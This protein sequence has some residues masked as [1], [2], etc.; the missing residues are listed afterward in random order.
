VDHALALRQAKSRFT[1]LRQDRKAREAASAVAVRHGSR[2]DRRGAMRQDPERKSLR[3]QE[4]ADQQ[5]ETSRTE[6]QT[7]LPFTYE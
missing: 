6:K 7:V 3:T 1:V 4:S 5:S 2:R